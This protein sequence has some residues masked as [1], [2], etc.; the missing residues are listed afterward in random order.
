MT[1][2]AVAAAIGLLFL[3]WICIGVGR[4]DAAN[5][6]NAGFGSRV[7][8]RRTAVM[9]AG[10]AVILGAASLSPVSFVAVAAVIGLSFLV[11][12]CVEVGRND[13]AN[14]V[15]AVFGA[16]VLK[17]RTAVVVAGVAVIL[18][19]AFSEQVMETARKGIFDPKVLTVQMALA[20]YISVYFVDTVLLFTFSGFGMPVST[21]ACLVFELV[22]A[23]LFLAG[24]DNVN[25]PNVG[26]V[27]LGILVSI[28]VSG[29]VSF[30]VMRAFRGAIRDRSQDETTVM[31]HGPWIVGAMLTWLTWF[32]V[33]K[34]LKHVSIVKTFKTEVFTEYGEGLVLVCMWAG[35]AVLTFAALTLTKKKIAPYLFHVTAVLGMVCMAFAF[36]QNDLANAASPGLAGYTLW[37]SGS[38]ATDLADIASE[39]EISWW[40]LAGCGILMAGGMLTQYAQRVTRAAV[41]TGSQYDNVALYAPEWCRRFARVILRFRKDTPALAPQPKL[42]ERGK[43][44]HY[45]ALRASVITAVSGSVIA[46]SSG[47]GLPVST[48]YVAF[49]A[50][51]GS[52]LADRVFARGDADLKLGR[53]VWVVT[54]WF[55]API[56]AILATGLV[57]LTVYH[58]EIAGLAVA[59]VANICVRSYFSRRSD[60]HEKK[61]HSSQD[62]DDD[63]DHA[64]TADSE[65]SAAPAESGEPAD[66]DSKGEE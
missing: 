6:V 23:S 33:F 61:H 64:K 56:V 17:R 46:F 65:E 13:A 16:R 51:L 60:A 42:N 9:V 15:N 27:I 3:V 44:L 31:L 43:K 54:C 22:G 8:K 52:G 38:A 10:V 40:A 45:D 12:D 47:H 34:G 24:P 11:W 26:T 7:L 35:F 29:M 50:V 57:A 63:E 37:Q 30:L 53:A 55:L 48:T 58:L 2:I 41:N 59:I 39:I 32:M 19:A 49:A 21:T 18:G 28:V 5:L 36:G 20:I 62:S 4:N 25:W 1:F 14:L 66:A